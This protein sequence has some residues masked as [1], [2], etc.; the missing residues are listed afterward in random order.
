MNAERMDERETAT[1]I[2]HVAIKL[3]RKLVDKA[4]EI[5]VLNF[6]TNIS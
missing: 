2:K 5:Y 4:L 1:K 3:N 6:L